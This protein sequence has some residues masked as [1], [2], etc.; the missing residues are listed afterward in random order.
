MLPRPDRRHRRRAVRDGGR[1]LARGDAAREQAYELADAFCEQ[2]R[3]RVEELFH[4]LWA[5]TD[6]LDRRLAGRVL[7]GEHVWLEAGVLD[8]SEGTGPWISTWTPGP[9][10]HDSVWRPYGG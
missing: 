3:L 2:A 1:L 5:N 7:E 8:Q 10:R 6:D 9:S 4:R